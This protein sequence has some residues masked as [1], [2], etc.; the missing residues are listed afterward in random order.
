MTIRSAV[1]AAGWKW[2]LLLM[3]ALLLAMD[4]WAMV[5]GER[6]LL[7]ISKSGDILATLDEPDARYQRRI[8]AF[9]PDSPLQAA[10]AKIGDRVYVDRYGDSQRFLGVDETIGMTIYADGAPARHVQIQPHPD[11][12][13]KEI[14]LPRA[15]AMFLLG[16]AT[17]LSSLLISAMIVLRRSDDPA[18]RVFVVGLMSYSVDHFYTVLPG[19]PVQDFSAIVLKP[20]GVWMNYCSFFYFTLIYPPERQLWLWPWVRRLFGAYGLLAGLVCVYRILLNARVLP[21]WLREH[22]TLVTWIS[23]VNVAAVVAGLTALLVSRRASQGLMRQKLTWIGV[24]VGLPYAGYGVS[25]LSALVG[26]EFPVVEFYLCQNFITL[27]STLGLGYALLRHRLF[28]F[29]FAVNR[30][31]VFTIISTLLLVV[32]SVTEWAVDKLLH[33][34]GR[35]KNAIFDALVAMG[36]ILSFHRVQHWVR[37]QVDH[38]FFHHWYE[39]AERLRSF[40]AKASHI[41]DPVQLQRKFLDALLE[42][43][44]ARG[45]AIYVRAA[46]GDFHLQHAAMTEAPAVIDRNDDAVIDLLYRWQQVELADGSAVPGRWLMPMLLRGQVTGFVLLGGKRSGNQYRPDEL[47]LLASGVQQLGLDLE[48]LRVE[49]LE[50]NAAQL[51]QRAAL[52]EERWHASEQKSAAQEREAAAL[53]Q[54]FQAGL[55]S[56]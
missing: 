23:V 41:S 35:E 48:S 32:F 45:G 34:E 28:D 47:A 6:Q 51:A 15:Q 37:H 17:V 33:F 29:G 49:E 31:L 30:A 20:L 54:L 21:W 22:V 50:R 26:H 4:L 40:I 11:P 3:M 10:G 14:S 2:F 1:P 42:Y 38:T 7:P 53:R 9:A 36:V 19:G 16:W 43:S 25:N 55:V 44:V 18:M 13:W 56:S 39:S 24:C 27:T 5:Y 52:M 8:A 12:V 46:S